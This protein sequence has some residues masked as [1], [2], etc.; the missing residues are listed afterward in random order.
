M[1]VKFAMLELGIDCEMVPVDLTKGDQAQPSFRAMNPFGR[2]PVFV[3]GDLTLWESHAILAYL[4]E[5]TG[6]RGPQ[7]RRDAQALKW[8][9]FLSQHISPPATDLAFNRVAAKLSGR[10]ID[11]AAIARGEKA[12][13]DVIKI[14]EG[15]LAANRWMLGADFSLVDC[16]YSSV[17]NVIEK[18]QFSFADFPEGQSLSRRYPRPASMEGDA[19][20]PDALNDRVFN[21]M[22]CVSD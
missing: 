5:K 8:L 18:A 10:P 16:A 1:K 20:A 13:P 6:K 17:L 19:Q 3:D 21:G 11:E 2:V 15:N 4:G 22:A 12:V 7:M 9:F 14:V